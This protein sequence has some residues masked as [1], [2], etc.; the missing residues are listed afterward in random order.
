MID[1]SQPRGNIKPQVLSTSPIGVQTTLVDDPVA[2][3]DDP[4]ALTGSQTT[5][6]GVLRTT[7]DSNAPSGSI[8]LQR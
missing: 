4:V 1:I 8:K 5:Q 6:I 7:A 2:L 3:V